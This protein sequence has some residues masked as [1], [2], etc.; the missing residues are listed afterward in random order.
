MTVIWVGIIIAVVCIIAIPFSYY[1][2]FKILRRHKK[3]IQN[4]N[5]VATR[6]HGFSET[7]IS[8]YRKSVFVILYVLVAVALSYLPSGI[9]FV[10]QLLFEMETNEFVSSF[11]GMLVILNSSINPL[12]YCWRITEIR[13]F[14]ISKLRCMLGAV[15][16][17]L[18]RPVENIS[19]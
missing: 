16:V 14:V 5:N 6:M 19:P 17:K 11:A 7:D 1:Q 9:S 10:V 4:Q 15:R 3:Q 13:R 2:I 12:V 8:K 18:V